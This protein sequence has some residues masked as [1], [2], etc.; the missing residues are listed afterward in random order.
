MPNID[1]RDFIK[2]VGAG[3]VGVGAG[4]VLRETIRDPREHLIPHVLAPED[5]SSGVATWYNSVC[6]MCKSGCGISV[7]T[8]E[9]R[10]KKIEGNPSHA[11]NQGG[12]CALGQAGLQVLYNP[13]RLTGPLIQSGT[14]GSDGFNQVTWDAGLG[15]VASRIDVLKAAGRG[16][17]VALLTHGVGGTLAT[18]FER[19]AE[20]IGTPRLHHYDYDHPHALYAA[21]HQFFGEQHLPYYDV[22]NTRYLLSFGADFLSSWLSPVHHSLGFAQSRGGDHARGHLVQIEPR[23]SL[24]GAAADEWVPAKT[25]TEGI[26]ALGLAHHI[27]ASGLYRGSDADEWR[28]VLAGYELEKVAAQTDVSADTL[29]HL[30]ESF[31]N[32]GPSLAIGGD[33]AANNTNGVDTLVAINALNYLAGNIG[34]AGGVLFNP[35]P[36]GAIPHNRQANFRDMMSLAAAAR[37]DEIEVLIINDTNPVFTMADNPEFAAAMSNVPLIVSLSSFMDETTA[38]A[39]V[40]LPSHVYLESWGDAF[41]EI[42]VGFS[43]GAV[44]QPVVAPLYNTQATGDIVLELAKRTGD[45]MPWS[46]MEAC[47]KDNWRAIYEQSDSSTQAESFDTFWTSLLKAGVWGK[48]N[49]RDAT[50]TLDKSAIA[51]VGVQ[52]PEFSGDSAD[53]P[54][55]LQPYLSTMHDGRG[56]NLPWVQELPDPMTSVVYGSWVE[57]NPTTAEELSLVEG[58]LVNIE[59]PEGSIQ[60]P[61][62]LFPAI[63]PDVV[64]MPIGQGHTN[65]GRYANGRGANPLE[66]LSPLIDEGSG[67]L[68]SNAT[69]VRILATGDHVDIVKT[70]GKSR[71]LGRDIVQTTSGDDHTAQMNNIPITVIPT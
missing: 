31:V 34:R 6:T 61:V 33:G 39:D 38:I 24:S 68:A 22:K 16:D 58:D 47:V 66:I 15:R 42:G 17:R 49:H 7:R 45:T 13:D 12:L 26:L 14:R 55:V 3:G 8:R 64:A 20:S 52:A 67:G 2:L 23:M 41:P 25:G 37:G 21:N 1:R 51:G 70:S 27:V 32:K 18:L 62:L 36:A 43:I 19:F 65:Y 50:V 46:S 30:A 57:L 10:A 56:A 9:G 29:E 63:R 60:A 35:E 28:Q 48:S 40:V 54:F 44:S 4:V 11:V 5:Y 59:S 71:D 69:R 53:Y